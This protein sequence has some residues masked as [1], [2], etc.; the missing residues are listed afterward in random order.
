M[1]CNIQ[2]VRG[3]F[4]WLAE[5]RSWDFVRETR[6]GAPEK[7]RIDKYVCSLEETLRKIEEQLHGNQD[8]DPEE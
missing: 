7:S 5:R 2:I 3:C 6:G 4:V 8:Q 1:C